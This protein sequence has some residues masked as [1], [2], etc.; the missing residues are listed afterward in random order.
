MLEE[1]I[2]IKN[3]YKKDGYLKDGVIAVEQHIKGI[4]LGVFIGHN[5]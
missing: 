4:K 3:L 2:L 1:E 5:S